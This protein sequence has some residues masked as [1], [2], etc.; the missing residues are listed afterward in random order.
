MRGVLAGV[1]VVELGTY[2]AAP[3]LGSILGM[4]GARVIK[5]EPPE[6]DPTRKTT[7]WSWVSY[8]WNKKSVVLDLKTPEG[9]QAML[10]LLKDADVL[11][12]SLSP[13]ATRELGLG[14]RRL[15]KLN[16]RIVH[17]SIKGFAGDSSSSER[18]GFDTIAQAEGGL[19]HVAGGGGRPSRV[20]IP[21]FDLT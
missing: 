6:G 20:G 5:V 4:L 9:S 1:K 12:E 18:V 16:P 17:C 7:P 13:R 11:V 2:V 10:R 3:A 14:F 15:R 8:N 21:C 19:M